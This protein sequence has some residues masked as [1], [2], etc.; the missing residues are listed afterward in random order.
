MASKDEKTFWY[1]MLFVGGV[2]AGVTISKL[3]PYHLKAFDTAGNVLID[4]QQTPTASP[5]P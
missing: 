4:L 3:V 1:I 2:V 5:R